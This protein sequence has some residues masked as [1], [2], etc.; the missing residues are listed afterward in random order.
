[1]EVN[2]AGPVGVVVDGIDM[3]AKRK[4]ESVLEG[5]RYRA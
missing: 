5:T 1:M 3:A 4:E 2:P